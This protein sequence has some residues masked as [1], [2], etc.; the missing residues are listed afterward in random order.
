MVPIR[1]T[2]LAN[3]RFLVLERI[4]DVRTSKA[5]VT[6]AGRL[7][8]VASRSCPVSVIGRGRVVCVEGGALKDDAI[9]RGKAVKPVEQG[10]RKGATPLS[11][12]DTLTSDRPLGQD[13][14]PRLIAEV[15]SLARARARRSEP[16]SEI[17]EQIGQRLRHVYNEVLFQPVPDRFHALLDA[18]EQGPADAAAQPAARRAPEQ[19][20]KDGK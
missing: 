14:E 10:I 15:A 17:I 3:L 4:L 19:A 13:H 2:L 6:I 9:S 16:K 8:V 12:A 1:G 18:L 20:K 11:K 7:Q 5:L